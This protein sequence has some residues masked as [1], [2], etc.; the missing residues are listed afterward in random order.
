MKV[1]LQENIDGVGYLG[2]LLSVADGFARNYLLPRGKAIEANTRNLKALEH[3]KRIAAQKAKKETQGLQELAKKISKVALT[4]PVQTGK[5]D[6][7]FGSITS[8]DV[9]EGLASHGVEVDRRKIQLTQPLKE[10]GEF[11]VPVK[12]HRE[13]VA[14][15]SVT[16]V[17]KDAEG[18]GESKAE[19]QETPNAQVEATSSG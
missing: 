17:K 9:G 6:K 5:D 12:L 2:D 8:K 7:L 16:L 19:E 1:I 3:L 11:T 18:E 13:V 10:L 15:V 14:D 4:F